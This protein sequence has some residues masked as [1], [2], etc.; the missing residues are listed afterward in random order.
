MSQPCSDGSWVNRS[1]S[2]LKNDDAWINLRKNFIWVTVYH[3]L[4]SLLI[5][6]LEVCSRNIGQ[7]F[8][9]MKRRGQKATHRGPLPPRVITLTYLLGIYVARI[10]RDY[11]R[12]FNWQTQKSLKSKTGFSMKFDLPT[13][14]IFGFIHW[15]CIWLENSQSHYCHS[16]LIFLSRSIFRPIVKK[17]SEFGLNSVHVVCISNQL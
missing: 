16:V 10:F 8:R 2:W 14:P 7:K 17:W 4:L 11:L 1:Q 3:V 15:I 6:M 13:T 5:F 9:K 12:V